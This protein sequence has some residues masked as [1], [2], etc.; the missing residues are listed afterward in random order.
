MKKYNCWE[1]LQCGREVGGDK[2]SELGV[3]PVNKN[4]ESDLLNE[5]KNGG[6]ICWAIAGTLCGEKVQGVFAQKRETCHMCPVY[7]LVK[8]EEGENFRELLPGQKSE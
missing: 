1:L 3:C 8:E 2:V 7:L 6:R 4:S 5:G